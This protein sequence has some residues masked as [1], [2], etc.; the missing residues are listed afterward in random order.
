MPVL[1]SQGV[2]WAQNSNRTSRMLA[3]AQELDRCT[4]GQ[5]DAVVRELKDRAGFVRMTDARTSF[6]DYVQEVITCNP[7]AKFD[8]QEAISDIVAQECLLWGKEE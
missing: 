4:R 2:L 3:M 8:V 7:N 6:S 5:S 1:V